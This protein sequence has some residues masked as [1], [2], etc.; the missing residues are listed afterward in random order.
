MLRNIIAMTL[1]LYVMLYM[2]A[3]LLARA[4]QSVGASPLAPSDVTVNAPVAAED[5]EAAGCCAGNGLAASPATEYGVVVNTGE[6]GLRVRSG[7]G[8]GFPTRVILRERATVVV[9]RESDPENPGGRWYELANAVDNEVF[10]WSAAPFIQRLDPRK[11]PPTSNEHS[12]VQARVLTMTVT[13]YSYQEPTG[14]AHGVLTRSGS[15][16]AWGVVAVDPTLIPLGSH[17]AI[18]G[19]SN[20]FVAQDTGFGIRGAHV[21]V[22]FP[23]QESARQFGVQVREVLV[24]DRFI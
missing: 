4:P 15:P 22:F 10:G 16:A 8:V 7:P 24:F 17:L 11:A 19:F 18:D 14:G 9:R 6:A 3:V 23:D 5:V 21:D 12:A 13:A 2:A 1:P 20:L